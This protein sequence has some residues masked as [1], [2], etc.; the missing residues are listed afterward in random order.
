MQS[1]QQQ[2]YALISR[3]GSSRTCMIN[4]GELA[5]TAC[6]TFSVDKRCN[7]FAQQFQRVSLR[8]TLSGAYRMF[9]GPKA[10]SP[11]P[12]FPLP[13]PSLPTP[14]PNPPYPSP[15]PSPHI[16][17]LPIF[18]PP[19]PLSPS[20]PHTLFPS[21]PYPIFSSPPPKGGPGV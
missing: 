3:L 16:I 2:H 4:G 19:L 5:I 15:N 13:S 17:P 20:P 21:P 6:R 7:E 11:R 10:P 1:T 18:T 14:N 8:P 12:P 9:L